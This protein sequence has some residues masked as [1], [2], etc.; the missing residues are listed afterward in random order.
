MGARRGRQSAEMAE[1]T[2]RALLQAAG[3]R[4]A[5]RGFRATSLRDIAD[6]AGTTHG[7]I[8]HH[9]G[10]KEDL[11]RAVVDGFVGRVVTEQ[12]PLVEAG[13]RSADPIGQLRSIAAVLLRAG[14]EQPDFARL[15]VLESAEPGPRLDYLVERIR[16][17]H[18]AIVPL[19]ERVK[20]EGRSLDDD[21][22]AFF[23]S[24][25]FAGSMPFALPDFASRF[26]RHD[27]RTE[28]GRDAHI[29]RVLTM[30]FGPPAPGEA[31]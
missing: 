15:V 5:E 25:L 22:G 27:P 14:A 30:L 29:E 7:M 18:E 17:A 31:D 2:R 9:F 28:V 19:F 21:A 20:A 13:L 3:R 23:L 24:L 1:Q 11:W 4:F 26:H 16:P 12:R 10:A 6:D 8:R